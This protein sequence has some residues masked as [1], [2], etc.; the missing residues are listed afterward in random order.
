D[1]RVLLQRRTFS[2]MPRRSTWPVESNVVGMG[3]KMPPMERVVMALRLST[4]AE[5]VND[6]G[7]PVTCVRHEMHTER[8][9]KHGHRGCEHPWS[10][11][12]HAD[13]RSLL[14]HAAPTRR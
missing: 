13:V 1:R 7:S 4:P 11:C 6:S 2:A 9:Q 3:G 5:T 10:T 14:E 12:Q 8:N